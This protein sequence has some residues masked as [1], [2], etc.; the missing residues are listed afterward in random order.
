M[1]T[2]DSYK[3]EP[4][5][6]L[7]VV[8]LPIDNSVTLDPAPDRQIWLS[9]ESGLHYYAQSVLYPTHNKETM[10]PEKMANCLVLS[11]P[12]Q[13]LHFFKA[14]GTLLGDSVSGRLNIRIGISAE[15][16]A[17]VEYMACL[18]EVM[19]SLAQEVKRL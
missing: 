12:G 15:D 14:D 3:L 18:G 17:A 2:S 6:G 8:I 1:V 4:W 19:K 9:D 16:R 5:N 13:K 11:H 10:E 7:K